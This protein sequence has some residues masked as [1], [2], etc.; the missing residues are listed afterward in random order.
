[1]FYFRY[2][3]KGSYLYVHPAKAENEEN[4]QEVEGVYTCNATNGYSFQVASANLTLPV[5]VPPP[6][7]PPTKTGGFN[8]LDYWWIFVIIVLIVLIVIIIIIIYYYCCFNKEVEYPGKLRPPVSLAT[9]P[10]LD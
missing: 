1:M 10:Y 5:D 6:T 9:P 7:F 3:L 2:E 8:I 4:R